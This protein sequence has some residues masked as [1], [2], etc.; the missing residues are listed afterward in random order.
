MRYLQPVEVKNPTEQGPREQDESLLVEGLEDHRLS[1]VLQG[2]LHSKV[3]PP[4]EDRLLRE[5][6][7]LHHVLDVRLL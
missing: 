7:A 4:P 3:A 1:L 6:D 2:E 5:D